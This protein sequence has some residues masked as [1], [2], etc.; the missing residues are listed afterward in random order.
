[1]DIFFPCKKPLTSLTTLLPTAWDGY[2]VLSSY[3]IRDLIQLIRLSE[4]D[5]DDLG[6]ASYDLAESLSNLYGDS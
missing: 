2:I 6:D 3:L 4:G 1:M 5:L